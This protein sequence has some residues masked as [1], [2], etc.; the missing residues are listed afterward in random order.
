LAPS[1]D[2]TRLASASSDGTIRIWDLATGACDAVIAI[3]SM[4]NSLR[5]LHDGKCVLTT[6]DDGR[7]KVVS[8]A[9]ESDLVL[10]GHHSYVY[11]A[12]FSPDS[13]YIVSAGWKDEVKV[14]ES[15]A[16]RLIATL[17]ENEQAL[18]DPP[19][20]V[21]FRRDTSELFVQAWYNTTR[22]W[23][24]DAIASG[25][26]TARLTTKTANSIFALAGLDWNA[27]RVRTDGGQCSAASADGTLIADNDGSDVRITTPQGELLRTLHLSVKGNRAVA[28]S[29]DGAT[30]AVAGDDAKVYLLD[31][32]TGEIQRTLV[33]HRAAVYTLAFS[34]DGSRLASGGNDNV[35]IIWDPKFG[36]SLLELRGHAAYVHAVSFSPDGASLV[37][38]SGDGTVRVWR[39]STH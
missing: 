23:N 30:L 33:G 38:A 32:L 39:A 6:D 5:W 28:F 3:E 18:W 20:I 22:Q 29:P 21:G 25:D 36:D 35:I 1:P 12:L 4:G 7:V 24:L 19:S 37:S 27:R 34:P 9:P 10:R 14:W 8:V 31:P 15:D 16:G 2:L 17:T 26:T 13:R 11:H